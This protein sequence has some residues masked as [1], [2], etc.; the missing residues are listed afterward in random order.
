[1]FYSLSEKHNKE[2]QLQRKAVH[3]TCKL[4]KDYYQQQ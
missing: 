4:S 3:F 1:M 2:K